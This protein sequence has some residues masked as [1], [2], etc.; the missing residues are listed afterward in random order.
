M[1]AN[2]STVTSATPPSQTA[3]ENHAPH[4]PGATVEPCEF[5]RLLHRAMEILNTRAQAASS[6]STA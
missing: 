4:V 1:N 3:S 5:E 2:D 6:N